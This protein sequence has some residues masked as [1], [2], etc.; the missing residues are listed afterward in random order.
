M[1]RPYGHRR[2]RAE[3]RRQAAAARRETG[4]RRATCRRSRPATGR[5]PSR[6][7]RRGSALEAL[8]AEACDRIEAWHAD[9]EPPPLHRHQGHRRPRQEH[10]PPA[11]HLLALRRRLADAGSPSRLAGAHAVARARRGGGR[12]L[13]GGRRERRGAPRLRGDRSRDRRRRCA[14]TLARSGQRI[15]AQVDVQSAACERRRPPLRL[16][17]QLPASSGTGRGRGR[18]RGDRRLRRALHR[19]AVDPASRRRRA[20]RRG[21]LEPRRRRRSAAAMHRELLGLTGDEPRGS[22]STLR[23]RAAE[24]LR[25]TAP[26]PLAPGVAAGRPG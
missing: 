13:A 8:L 18:R 21:L 7:P 11:A 15:E 25:A 2:R 23:R 17:R 24:A 9:P 20:D 5:R 14:A 6:S 12:R 26:G 4:C 16:L 22:S 10:R 19:L 3:G 1:A